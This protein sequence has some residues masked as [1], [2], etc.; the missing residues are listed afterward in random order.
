[1]H[2]AIRTRCM[3]RASKGVFLSFPGLG[4]ARPVPARLAGGA[5]RREH[6]EVADGARASSSTFRLLLL[7][8]LPL[9]LSP[10]SM[11]YASLLTCSFSHLTWL[12]KPSSDVAVYNLVKPVLNMAVLKLSRVNPALA[13]LSSTYSCMQSPR[14]DPALTLLSSTFPLVRSAAPAGRAKGRERRPGHH[15]DPP[16]LFPRGAPGG[17]RRLRLVRELLH[18]LRLGEW[19]HMRA[20][21]GFSRE[22][23]VQATSCRSHTPIRS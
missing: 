3:C 20:R 21:P 19:T 14:I 6:T 4:L 15:H 2:G 22:S 8:S 23:R 17:G 1:V 10:S 9:F 11:L 16:Q 5:F 12:S 7:G 18:L 13:L